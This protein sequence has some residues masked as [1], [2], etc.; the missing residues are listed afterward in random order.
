M[1]NHRQ[2]ICHIAY[3]KVKKYIHTRINTFIVNK[4]KRT[5]HILDYI[6]IYFFFF[7]VVYI[8]PIMYVC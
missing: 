7:V 4:V 3:R 6:F 8:K 1:Y 2:P 5:A